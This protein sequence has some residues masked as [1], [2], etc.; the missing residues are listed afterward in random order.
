[1]D[2]LRPTNPP[3]A[4]S[5]TEGQPFSILF[6]ASAALVLGVGTFVATVADFIRRHQPGISPETYLLPQARQILAP[7]LGLAAA[8]GACAAVAAYRHRRNAGRS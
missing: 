2:D 7:G 4:R 1:M 6:L 3:P 5:A 8:V